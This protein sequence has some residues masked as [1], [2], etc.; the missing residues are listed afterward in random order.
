MPDAFI[1]IG[2]GL[3]GFGE[4]PRTRF[5]REIRSLT[6]LEHPK[7]GAICEKCGRRCAAQDVG[8]IIPPFMTK[9]E[10]EWW[11]KE[12]RGWTRREMFERR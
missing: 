3:F 10:E 9:E 12:C 6:G 5:R 4:G 8:P 2:F 1:A 11:C 7:W